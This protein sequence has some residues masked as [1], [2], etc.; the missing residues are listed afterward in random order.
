MNNDA[1]KLLPTYHKFHETP[2]KGKRTVVEITFL[3]KLS[4]S[5]Q[6][7]VTFPKLAPN[8]CV[9]PDSICILAMFENSNTK[10]WLKN[11]LGRL[12]CRDFQM[13]INLST[14]YDNN[15]ESLIMVYK[16]LWL[17]DKRREDMSKYGIA[18]ENLRKLMSVVYSNGIKINDLY[19]EARR[20]FHIK[21]TNMTEKKFYDN[22][23]ALVIDLRSVDDNNAVSAGY[24]VSDTKSGVRLTITKGV[25]KRCKGRNIR[26]IG[27]RCW[28]C[29]RRL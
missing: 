10:S 5:S 21:D 27:C 4:S 17:P 8:V 9:V 11:N 3:P 19:R 28:H 12:L 25:N 18:S 29:W 16:D 24:N 6:V 15:L 20:V 2:I 7:N 22:K 1:K 13:R 14:V 23:F 26:A